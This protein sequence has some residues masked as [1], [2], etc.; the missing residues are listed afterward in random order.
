[1]SVFVYSEL[2]L[3]L[4]ATK[5]FNSTL[6]YYCITLHCITLHCITLHYITLHYITLHYITLHYIALHCITLH[7]TPTFDSDW[8]LSEYWDKSLREGSGEFFKSRNASR[9]DSCL[10]NS[11][12]FLVFSFIF[13]AY[14]EYHLASPGDRGG[15][16]SPSLREVL[17]TT[18]V[19]GGCLEWG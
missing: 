7:F 19:A 9:A 13:E 15:A 11:S 17:A 10:H 1:M 8:R 12:P 18:R 3:D 4:T 2:H 16:T 14:R 5:K 6:L